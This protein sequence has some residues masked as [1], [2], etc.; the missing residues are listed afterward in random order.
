MCLVLSQQWKFSL[1][2]LLVS[3]DRL[4]WGLRA[5]LWSDPKPCMRSTQG[6]LWDVL[7]WEEVT[8]HLVGPVTGN[9][10]DPLLTSASNLQHL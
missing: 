7:R 6:L 5:W 4:S 8:A 10:Q 9:R 2:H 1:F 3:H